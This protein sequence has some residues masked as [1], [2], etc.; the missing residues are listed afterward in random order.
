MTGPDEDVW[1]SRRRESQ[2]EALKAS[3]EL[4]G[5]FDA[6]DSWYVDGATRLPRVQLRS[7]LH[8]D[9]RRTSPYLLSSA[10]TRNLLVAID[11]LHSLRA[12]LFLADSLQ[13]YAPFTLIRG[14]LEGSI[15]A[16]WLLKPEQRRERISRHILACRADDRDQNTM[17]A[18]LDEPPAKSRDGWIESL[19]KECDL[20]RD[21]VKGGVPSFGSIVKK[22]DKEIWSDGDNLA[23]LGW[24]MCSGMAHGREWSTLD[25][26]Y[27][28]LL[29]EHADGVAEVRLTAGMTDV[30]VLTQLAYMMLTEAVGL[31][32]N[33]SAPQY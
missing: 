25:V 29:K 1:T 8:G 7:S 26:L 31:Y 11:H 33:R 19:I 15:H 24:R 30:S 32:S 2:E 27:R 12:S 10:V 18:C 22:V 17:A 14:S 5:I 23:E 20:D 13:T 16:L 28:Q 21:R 9:D 4:S 3:A 6:V